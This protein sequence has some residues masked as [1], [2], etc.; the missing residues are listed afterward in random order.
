ME[1]TAL[2]EA[3]AT[4]VIDRS[5]TLSTAQVIERT[6]KIREVMEAVMKNGVHYG[7]IPGTPKPTMYQPGADVLNVTFRITPKI[8]QIE[9]LSHADEIRYRI[10][11]E[12]VHQ[13]SG[14]V[15]SEG[16]GE[17]SS[18]EEKYRYRK[19]VC[20]EE[21]TETA[22]DLRR[23]KWSKDKQ[24]KGY[25]TKQV[26]TSPADVANTVLKMAVKR[27]KVAM[28]IS[29]TAASDVFAQDLEDLS[30]ELREHLSDEAGA[31][32]APPQPAQRKSDQA[33]GKTA[34]STGKAAETVSSEPPKNIGVIVQLEDKGNGAAFVHL[35]TTFV[36]STRDEDM[37]KA[38]A[39]LRDGKRRVELVTVPSADPKKY[40][41]KLTE[42][43]P[44]PEAQA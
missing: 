36:C 13:I 44:Q 43:N 35:D 41:P 25:K 38:A 10:T 34:E 14:D 1:Y 19:A 2:V 31:S 33:N 22:A 30:E 29:A 18:N 42:I 17:C 39:S 4:A 27:A 26:R 23:E 12:G 7:V 9:D 32:T 40:A 24:G 21:W 20:A 3:P 15:L 8:K 6:K 37:M 28:T 11:V 16:V 5:H